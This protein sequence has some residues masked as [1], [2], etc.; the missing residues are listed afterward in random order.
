MINDNEN[1][2][3]NEKNITSIRHKYTK[4]KLC[5]SMMMVICVKQDLSNI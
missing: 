4:Y 1:E 2:V 5:L 3:E